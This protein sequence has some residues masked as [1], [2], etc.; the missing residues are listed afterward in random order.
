M[1]RYLLHIIISFDQ[2]VCTLIGGWPDETISSYAYRLDVEDKLGGRIFRPLIDLLFAILLN[3][4]NHCENA[5][6]NETNRSQL[7]ESFRQ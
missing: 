1:A 3:D 6:F 4:I 2:F 5:W 7:P